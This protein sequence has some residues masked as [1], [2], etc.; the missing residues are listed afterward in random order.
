MTVRDCDR[1][2]LHL[3]GPSRALKVAAEAEKSEVAGDLVGARPWVGSVGVV[4]LA[5]QIRP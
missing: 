3:A 2:D 5:A 1:R 4:K